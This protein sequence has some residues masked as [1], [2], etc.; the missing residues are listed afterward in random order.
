MRSFLAVVFISSAAFAGAREENAIVPFSAA[1]PGEGL[2]HGWRQLTLPRIRPPEIEVVADEGAAVLR[3]RSRAA[4][5][6]AAFALPA[7]AS[8]VG[9]RLA[10]RWKIDRV[11]EKA[12]LRRKSADDFAA[13]V[14]VFFDVPRQK[15]GLGERT[16]MK[17]AKLLYGA[18][19]PPAV[20]CYVWDNRHPVGT[21]AWSP[22]SRRVR[23]IVLQSGDGRAGQWVAES[24]DV[25]EDFRAAFGAT[26]KDGGVPRVSGV[27][28]GNDTDQTGDS[29]TAWFGDIRLE[30]GP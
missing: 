3:V 9:G 22:Y 18:E 10:W 8:A 5:G 19:A 26:W 21:S 7:S 15:L 2:P 12:D 1:A 17:L 6:T 16:K 28:A 14:Y 23:T 4:G 24:R 30:G 29:V 25:D 20:I 27:A 13:R 11:V